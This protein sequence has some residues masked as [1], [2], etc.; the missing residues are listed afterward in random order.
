[1][2]GSVRFVKKEKGS[3][4]RTWMF[5]GRGNLSDF[6]FRVGEGAPWV[7][8]ARSELGYGRSSLPP[9]FQD[10]KVVCVGANLQFLVSEGLVIIEM[11]RS[12]LIFLNS[13]AAFVL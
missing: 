11:P 6:W 13:A 8:G 9:S 2:I 7:M 5:S 10:C 3:V 1:M 4:A 12:R